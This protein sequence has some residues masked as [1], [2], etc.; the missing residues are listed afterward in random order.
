MAQC[1]LLT[2]CVNR[3]GQSNSPQKN[4]ATDFESLVIADKVAL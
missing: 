1:S 3:F 2:E 4:A